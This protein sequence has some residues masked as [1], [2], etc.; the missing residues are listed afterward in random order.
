[1]ALKSAFK[2]LP[3]KGKTAAA[4]VASVGAG[5]A[6]GGL[7]SSLASRFAPI[8]AQRAKGRGYRIAI[9]TLAGLVLVGLVASV[10]GRRSAMVRKAAPLMAGGALYSAA[11]AEV[12]DAIM[13]A[14]SSIA[15][16]LPASYGASSTPGGVL[17]NL[18]APGGQ[19]AR[20][21]PVRAFASLAPGKQSRVSY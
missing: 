4:V 14:T 19:A 9:D 8:Q 12:D 15:G 17:R 16:L 10:A 11:K 21:G 20:Q 18:P 5:M 2:N 3:Q 6:V 7:A 13:R 1:M